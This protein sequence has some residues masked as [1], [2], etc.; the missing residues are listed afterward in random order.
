MKAKRV[1][2]RRSWA[3]FVLLATALA[4]AAGDAAE[5]PYISPRDVDLARFLPPPPT[6]DSAAQR[7]D[8]DAVLEIQRTRTKAQ[9]ADAQADQKTSVFRFADVLGKNFSE[10]RLPKTAAL[11]EKA[12]RETSAVVA[13][14]KQSWS[15][16][17]PYVTS[18]EVKPVL[19]NVTA[20]SYPSGHA[21]CGYIWAIILADMIPEK[22]DE[23]IV[24]GIRYGQNRVV[25][26]VH[27]PTDAEA[28]RLSG[29]VIAVALSNNPV[30]R[31][32]FDSA[33]A[34]LREVM[35]YSREG[36]ALH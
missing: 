5:S 1:Q 22:R 24:R 14:A 7:R 23:L 19:S 15:R 9:I 3:L 20:G 31:S 18:R 26:G 29:A 28:G 12:C 10:D 17:R 27:Y 25:G 11:A 16:P 13:V 4:M 21:T 36:V 35:G 2:P 33:K 30:F 34:E 6:P 32:D 8:L